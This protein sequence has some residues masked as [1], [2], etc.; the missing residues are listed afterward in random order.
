[1]VTTAGD[2]RSRELVERA[3]EG[4][5]DAIAELRDLVRG[6]HPAVLTDRGLDAAVS[7]LVARSP[8]PVDMRSGL[9]RRLPGAVESA[10][11]FVVAEASTNAMK[12]SDATLVRVTIRDDGT[13]L[14]IE[15]TDDAQTSKQVEV[16]ESSKLLGLAGALPQSSSSGIER[17]LVDVTQ[18]ESASFRRPVDTA[19]LLSQHGLILRAH[20]VARVADSPSGSPLLVGVNVEAPRH[21]QHQ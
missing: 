5:K 12:H 20:R 8:L 9:Q 6:I 10:A 21:R 11:Y 18:R 15:V 19:P 17:T 3:H 7:A 2:D 14:M 4:L 1:M 13:M 16:T